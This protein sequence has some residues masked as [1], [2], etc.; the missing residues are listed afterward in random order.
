MVPAWTARYD[1][2]AA[3]GDFATTVKL[4]TAGNAYVSGLVS[5]EAGASDLALVKYGPSGNQLWAARYTL[6]GTF[7]V[8]AG[9]ALDA[10]GNSYVA[11]SI[12]DTNNSDVIILKYN[13]AGVLQWARRFDGGG[14]DYA[15]AV[16]ADAL[17]NVYVAASQVYG[18][19]S[20]DYLTLK[21]TTGGSLLWARTYSVTEDN[22]DTPRAVAVDTSGNVYVSGTAFTGT[23]TVVP[24]VKYDPNGNTLWAALYRAGP[25]VNF[26]GVAGVM[27]DGGGDVYVGTS[28]FTNGAFDMVVVKYNSSGAEQ[29]ASRYD[30]GRT[31]DLFRELTLDAS[32]NVYV[33][34]TSTGVGQDIVAIKFGP[35]GAKQWSSR[36][37]GAGN[38]GDVAASVRV[39]GSGNVYVGGTA[40]GAGSQRDFVAIMYD[41]SG[42]Q[43]WL[44]QYDNAGNVD[45]VAGMELGAGPSLIL[46]GS[47]FFADTQHDFLTI[48]YL[49][50]PIAGRPQIL[51]APQDRS[52]AVGLAPTNVEFSVTVSGPEPIDYRWRQNGAF[53]PGA[54]GPTL[55]ITDVQEHHRGGYS[56]VVS[57]GAGETVT[58]EA[59]LIVNVAPRIVYLFPTSETVAEGKSVI[60]YS[61]VTGDLPITLQWQHNGVDLPGQTNSYLDMILLSTNASGLYRLRASNPFGEAIS[62][63]VRLSV[64]P[65]TT[66]DRWTWRHPLP[67][68]NDLYG[69]AFGNGRFVAVGEGGTIISSTDGTNWIN[70][71][72]EVSD[73]NGIV[74]GNGLFLAISL[75]YGYTSP[76]GLTWT[77][78]PLPP[79][80][81][82]LADVVS[83]AYGAGVFVTTGGGIFVSSNAVDW[84]DRTGGIQRFFPSVTYGNGRFVASANAL[85][86]YVSTNG[87]D[88]IGATNG[89]TFPVE[90]VAFGN[91]VFVGSY[92]NVVT[93]S[94]D[95]LMWSPHQI[96]TNTMI[97]NLAFAGGHFLGLGQEIVTSPDGSNW[98]KRL[99]APGA[100][101]THAAFGNGL[102]VVV[103][104]GG[105]ILTSSEPASW[106]WISTGTDNNLR[107]IVH[108][109]N[110][111]VVVGNDGAAW[112]SFDG[113][114]WSNRM[115]LTTN[116]LRAIAF[117][118]DLFVIAGSGGTLLSSS[119][120][121]QWESHA[122][123]T[124][125]LYGLVFI[126]GRF[127]AVGDQ[128]RIVVSTNGRE[129]LATSAGTLRR[130]QGITY[131]GGLY[132]ATGQRGIRARSYNA[133]NWVVTA[134]DGLG[135]SEAV[136]YT[137]G[138]FVAVGNGSINTS[139]DGT[140]WVIQTFSNPELESIIFA[141]GMFIAGGD[142][143]LIYTSTNAVDWVRRGSP[144]TR[145]LRQ[146]TY[147][148]GSVWAVGNNEAILQ[149]GQF[150][151]HLTIDSFGSAGA[152][153]SV[154]AEP[155]Q[156]VR[157]QASSNLMNW[158]TLITET[159]GPT[160]IFRYLDNSG[161]QAQRFYR[162]N[163]P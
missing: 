114:S 132:V 150:H 119:E 159:V 93:V 110:R 54:T 140:N 112:V 39:D 52:V 111:F 139:S 92:N 162:A 94:Q 40:T 101:F 79:F 6:P 117:G 63:P 9:L 65:R 15:Y 16:A 38:A 55:Q 13:T 75:G 58:P 48:K 121:L 23:A 163:V 109:K 70:S 134:H 74:Y 7:D 144:S 17:G 108:A 120:G 151:P 104:H 20:A 67:Q 78:Q 100:V 125:D 42:N 24:T 89:L 50:D 77:Q 87:W 127:V 59:Q 11:G 10:S 36:Y 8:G 153:L 130:L 28:A 51:S 156:L 137:N 95:G 88:W 60:F 80:S 128:G 43:Q 34:G 102:T 25:G 161:G 76:D 4:D 118:H 82:F 145:S 19:G 41:A 136:I 47:S 91:G 45:D 154:R 18:P 3:V 122:V 46:A 84:V 53:I 73:I 83:V 22:Q 2:G 56:V 68:G 160:D 152:Q 116:N 96:L 105:N 64:V 90:N 44:A 29:W 26:D 124:N 126:N 99:N 81:P 98:T 133:T 62:E 1:S 14:N 5:A 35:D 155:G 57:N 147:V 129:W 12:Y 32:G 115:A 146:L 85:E 158:A 107:G 21:Y 30:S 31:D 33:T 138:L 123:V 143:G 27:V 142:R 103:G 113:L 69:V 135:Y 71:S 72:L 148:N 37:S 49:P 97:Y 131:G 66:I 141:E 86:T 149:S 106:N 61:S 157:I